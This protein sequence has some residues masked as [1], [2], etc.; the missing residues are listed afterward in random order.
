MLGYNKNTKIDI[1]Q[2]YPSTTVHK[3]WPSPKFASHR[4]L[5]K[6]NVMI[7]A[8]SQTQTQQINFV[9]FALISLNGLMQWW[10]PFGHS[11]QHEQLDADA[12]D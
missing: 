3:K 5:A 9:G 8:L 1:F 2:F 11:I 7:S 10:L 4:V 12:D 6:A